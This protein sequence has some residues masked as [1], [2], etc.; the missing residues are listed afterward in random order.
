MNYW[1][2][3]GDP[4]AIEFARAQVEAADNIT[5][6]EAALAAIVSGVAPFKAQLLLDLARGWSH[7]PLLMNKW[8]RLQATAAA[9]AGEPP[10]LARVKVLTRHAAYSTS[11]P[12]NVYALVLAFCTHNL[13]EFHRD[14]GAGYAFWVEQVLQLDRIN[15]TVAARVAR[16]LDRWRKFTPSRKR[17]MQ[18][19]LDEVARTPSL[20]RDVREIV[21]KALEN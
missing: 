6:R 16:A 18:A 7:E 11:N 21:T 5:D 10:V 13:A 4:A 3:S 9:L 17:Q 19:A 1:V 15:P 2:D 12:N 14:D 20:S 8:F